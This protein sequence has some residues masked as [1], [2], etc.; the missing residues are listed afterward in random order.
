MDF[1]TYQIYHPSLDP[2]KEGQF[3][4]TGIPL[5]TKPDLI[6][7]RVKPKFNCLPDEESSWVNIGPSLESCLTRLG[8]EYK[9]A[10]ANAWLRNY[11][12][13]F[14]NGVYLPLTHIYD[15]GWKKA[16]L[17]N[18]GQIIS[19]ENFCLVS[20]A[21]DIGHN[22]DLI[23]RELRKASGLD[24]VQVINWYQ[25]RDISSDM[26]EFY[27]DIDLSIGYIPGA[28]L[29]V[30]DGNY[31][32]Q[33]EET[34]DSIITK[35]RAR[36]LIT[37]ELFAPNFLVFGAGEDTKVITYQCPKLTGDLRGL[38]INAFDAVSNKSTHWEFI[39]GGGSVRCY[40]NFVH[41]E[42]YE[43]FCSDVKPTR[44]TADSVKG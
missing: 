23:I 4:D 18:G 20:G 42:L 8:I 22:H 34:I 15:P 31:Y 29:F 36:L 41:A 3:E 21:C 11:W 1:T 37:D 9:Q 12:H 28:N 17:G 14:G 33:E 40:T 16:V 6:V 44:L 30:V 39:D 24:S 5:E 7:G 26:K 38:G 32:L 2:E 10:P 27:Q 35:T 13:L 19:G 25:A 43:K